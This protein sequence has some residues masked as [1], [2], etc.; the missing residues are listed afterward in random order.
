MASRVVSITRLVSRIL[1]AAAGCVLLIVAVVPKWMPT[2]LVDG[3]RVF[4]PLAVLG[5]A[6][7]LYGVGKPAILVALAAGAA[8]LYAINLPDSAYFQGGEGAGF[9]AP[10]GWFLAALGLII[11]RAP[12]AVATWW[13]LLADIWMLTFLS[14]RWDVWG[15]DFFKGP[16]LVGGYLV[17]TAGALIIVAAIMRSLAAFAAAFAEEPSN[18][19]VPEADDVSSSAPR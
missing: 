1:A 17:A 11:I 14:S 3:G 13:L 2:Y 18:P 9:A 7:V 15:A 19:K 6:A 12:M 4:V 5:L 16:H 8:E 10:I